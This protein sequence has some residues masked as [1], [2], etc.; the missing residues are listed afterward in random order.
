VVNLS[1]SSYV[2]LVR[3]VYI[4]RVEPYLW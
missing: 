1:D 4:R 3:T 2:G